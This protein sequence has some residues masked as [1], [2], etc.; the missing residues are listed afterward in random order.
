MSYEPQLII[1]K[2]DLEKHEKLFENTQMI[3]AHVA[4]DDNNLKP[5]EYLAKVYLKNNTFNIFGIKCIIC[6]PQLTLFNKSVRT[7][8]RE[9]EIEFVEII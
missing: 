5:L 8:L 7:K 6:E 2:S 9:L 4:E 3:F 1:R